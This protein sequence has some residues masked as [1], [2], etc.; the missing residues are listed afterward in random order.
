MSWLTAHESKVLKGVDVAKS[1]KSR[2]K[3]DETSESTPE[4]DE[5]VILPQEEDPGLEDHDPGLRDEDVERAEVAED[6]QTDDPVEEFDD[7]FDT[8]DADAEHAEETTVEPP[9]DERLD[10]AGNDVDA[11]DDTFID[12]LAEDDYDNRNDETV[13]YEQE[14]EAEDPDT[15]FEEDDYAAPAPEPERE[16]VVQKVGLI[17]LVLGGAIAAGLGYLLA[18]FYY[19]QPGADFEAMIRAQSD[20]IAELEAQVA[21]LPTDQPDLAPLETRIEDVQAALSDRI[22]TLSGD[23]ETQISA[24]DER[25]VAVERAPAEDGTLAE[26]AIASWER[27]LEALRE[28]FLAQEAQMSELTA[29][30]QADLEAARAEA[31]AV[32]QSAAEAARASVSRAALSRIQ[33]A[34]D[35]GSAFDAALADLQSAGVEVPA[36][37]AAV[38]ADGAPTLATLRDEFP[39]AARA[40]LSAARAEGLADDGTNPLTAFLRDQ[41]DVRSVVPREGDDPDAILSRAEAALADDRLTDALAEI[42]SLPEVARAEMSGWIEVATARANALAAAETIDQSLSN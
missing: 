31:E 3:K 30:A 9:E 13:E 42:D 4:I 39:A 10:E 28:E 12:D 25:L 35:S 11:E 24:F 1:G 36:E 33:V 8:P 40:V 37:L 14:F 15:R 16:V 23:M 38:A 6:T 2:S 41:L 27:E 26:T 19:G 32:E 7:T 34:L 22:E 21:S 20:R 5:A 17:P 18:F 29:Q